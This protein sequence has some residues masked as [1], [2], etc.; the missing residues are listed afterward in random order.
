MLWNFYVP[1]ERGAIET[2][3]AVASAC[4]KTLGSNGYQQVMTMVSSLVTDGA[5]WNTCSKTGLLSIVEEQRKDFT[6][7][8][9]PPL[10]KIWCAEHRSNLAWESV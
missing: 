6:E 4:N 3:W 5:T 8:Q 1:E 10:L 9:L 7:S 2:A